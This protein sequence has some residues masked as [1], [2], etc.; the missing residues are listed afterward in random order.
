MV[1]SIN[2]SDR[3]LKNI[4]RNYNILDINLDID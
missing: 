3:F 1:D 2:L 4:I